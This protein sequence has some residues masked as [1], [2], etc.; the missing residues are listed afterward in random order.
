MFWLVDTNILHKNA[1][2]L[3]NLLL[4]SWKEEHYRFPVSPCYCWMRDSPSSSKLHT[5][6]RNVSCYIHQRNVLRYECILK[7]QKWCFCYSRVVVIAAHPCIYQCMSSAKQKYFTAI[8]SLLKHFTNKCVDTCI[9][10]RKDYRVLWFLF[11]CYVICS[12]GDTKKSN[13]MEYVHKMSL[14]W[15]S[16]PVG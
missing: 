13:C 14:L 1:A 10:E 16:I 5:H 11:Q 8:S 9:T 15:H 6:Q 2:T 12:Y 4:S 7:V 3:I